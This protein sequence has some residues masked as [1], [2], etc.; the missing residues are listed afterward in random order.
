[1]PFFSQPPAAG[2]SLQVLW[3]LESSHWSRFVWTG[4][5]IGRDFNPQPPSDAEG[6]GKEVELNAGKDGEELLGFIFLFLTIQ[7]HFK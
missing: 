5:G 7:M 6:A 2:H 3:P 1:M 4:G